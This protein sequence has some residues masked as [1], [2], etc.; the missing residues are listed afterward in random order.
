MKINGFILDIDNTLADSTEAHYDSWKWALEKN[1]V[2][3]DRDVVVAEFGKPTTKIAE[4]LTNGDSKLAKVIAREKTDFLLES[5]ANVGL[6]DKVEELINTLSNSGYKIC[7]ASSNFNRVIEEF[8]KTH[9]WDKI[10]EGFAGIDDVEFA[11]PHPGMIFKCI[12]L[13]KLPPNQC[14]MI[15]DSIYD[16]EAGRRAGTHTIGVCTGHY[17]KNELQ[18]FKPDLILN[19]IG[20]LLDLLPLDL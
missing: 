15:G 17:G 8:V 1:G 14:V 13:M 7:F 10:A 12:G 3:K 4:I 20:E 2:Y 18:K 16:I 19:E 6:F 11:K 9:N 5:F